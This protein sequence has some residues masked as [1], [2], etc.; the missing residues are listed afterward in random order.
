MQNFIAQ[1]QLSTSILEG[2]ALV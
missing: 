2:C 1:K